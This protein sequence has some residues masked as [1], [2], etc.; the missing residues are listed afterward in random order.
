MGEHGIGRKLLKLKE[1]L[2][3]KKAERSEFQGEYNGLMTQ[4]KKEFSI[5]KV[6][7]IKARLDDLDIDIETLDV[8]IT[9]IIEQVETIFEG[10]EE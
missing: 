3:D 5:P 10:V 1:E 7:E 8:S 4:L 2:E 9:D 6:D